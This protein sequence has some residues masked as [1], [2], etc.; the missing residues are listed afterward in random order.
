[1]ASRVFGSS[2]RADAPH[3]QRVFRREQLAFGIGPG[4]LGGG[5]GAPD[6]SVLEISPAA[7]AII[8]EIAR[9]IF[10]ED[11]AALLIDYGHAESAPGETLQAVRR[12]AYADPLAAPG[13]ADLTAH[14]DFAALARRIR[15]EGATAHGPLSQGEF[16]LALGL[17]ERAGQLGAT[18]DDA[19]RETIRAAVERLAGPARMGSLFKAMAVT[20]PCVTPPP[21]GEQV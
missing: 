1:M 5:P 10:A 14:V 2:A 9:R 15:A 7:D 11:G 13:E 21:F 6:G 20:R 17:L 19:T 4:R 8:A 3:R 16:L 12:H 18:A